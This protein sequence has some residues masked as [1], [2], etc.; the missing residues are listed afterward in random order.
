VGLG[1]LAAI[2]PL[3]KTALNK[4]APNKAAPNKAALN[5]TPL[6]KYRRRIGRDGF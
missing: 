5:K 1:S 6:N 2:L 3:S 4:A